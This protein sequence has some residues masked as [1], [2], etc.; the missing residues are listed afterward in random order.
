MQTGAGGEFRDHSLPLVDRIWGIWFF[1]VDPV[2]YLLEG[3]HRGLGFRVYCVQGRVLCSPH[4]WEVVGQ[5]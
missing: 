4:L 1:L 3:D 2:F 5:T